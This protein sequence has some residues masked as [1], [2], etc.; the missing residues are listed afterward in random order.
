LLAS[1]CEGGGRLTKLGEASCLQLESTSSTAIHRGGR[2][3]EFGAGNKCWGI[4]FETGIE[5]TFIVKRGRG[6]VLQAAVDGDKPLGFL[7]ERD[8]NLIGIG[9]V[10]PKEGP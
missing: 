1:R 2:G 4:Y 3:D 9:E 10:R 6:V 8:V 7:H 5:L